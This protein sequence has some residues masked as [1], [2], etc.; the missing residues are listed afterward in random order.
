M[1]ANARGKKN[2]GPG[3]ARPPGRDHKEV[4]ESQFKNQGQSARDRKAKAA[5]VNLLVFGNPFPSRTPRERSATTPGLRHRLP[6]THTTASGQK[7]ASVATKARQRPLPDD[8][9]KIIN[10]V[11]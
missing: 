4:P 7:R 11:K 2:Y 10:A 9:L 8:M 3:L 1:Y 6:A 5:R